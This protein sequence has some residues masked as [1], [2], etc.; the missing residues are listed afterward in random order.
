MDLR[1]S[2][3]LFSA[4]EVGTL[5]TWGVSQILA[6][7]LLG[8]VYFRYNLFKMAFFGLDNQEDLPVLASIILLQL[9][10]LTIF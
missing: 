1:S 4:C 7:L 3:L 2:F 6:Y 5:A 8:A 10:L 9:G